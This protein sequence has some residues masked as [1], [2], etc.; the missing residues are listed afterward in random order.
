MA[1]VREAGERSTPALVAGLSS[2]GCSDPQLRGDGHGR[3]RCGA[4]SETG[5]VSASQLGVETTGSCGASAESA[6][7]TRQGLP[8]GDERRAG[9]SGPCPKSPSPPRRFGP[10]WGSTSGPAGHP[11]VG[12]CKP[13]TR[14][15][16]ESGRRAWQVGSGGG[17]EGQMPRTPSGSAGSDR[18]RN[19]CHGSGWSRGW[20]EGRWRSPAG[21]RVC[22]PPRRLRCCRTVTR[23][24]P[25]AP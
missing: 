19:G 6:A 9:V 12:R 1:G 10:R 22:G 14:A 5:G 17:G 3:S 21:W 24:S 25:R 4:P 20:V 23:G 11:R 13:L 2:R 8:A 16:N 18:R 7:G 15:A